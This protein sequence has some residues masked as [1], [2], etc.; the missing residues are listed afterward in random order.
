MDLSRLK[1]IQDK[2]AQ[3]AEQQVAT[4]KQELANLQLQETIVQVAK[5]VVEF[6]QGNT[7]KTVVLNQIQ[8][9]AT[10]ADT[11]NVTKSINLLHETLKTHENVD[12]TELTE[13]MSSA[14]EELKQIPKELPE[15]AEQKFVDYTEQL[16][17]LASAVKA[18]DESIKAQETTVEAPVVNVEAPNVEVKAPDL[19]PLTKE[20]NTAF[21]KAIKSIVFPKYEVDTSKIEKEQKLQT[22]LLKEIRDTPSGSGGGG[23]GRAT[24]YQDSNDIPAF[25]ELEQG[26]IPTVGVNLAVRIDDTTT[27]DTTYIGKAP[28]GTATSSASWQI[29]SLATSSGLIKTWADGDAQ[30]NNIW[31]NRASLTYN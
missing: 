3:Q 6:I 19:K 20:V 21:S 2:Q 11:E 29:A 25:V 22:K 18:V 15:Q 30:F 24:P 14:L 12:L 27:A 5:S 10:S 31:D 4:T 28:I 26:G 7:S 13:V 8:D 23:G 1:A 9:F 17:N 16:N